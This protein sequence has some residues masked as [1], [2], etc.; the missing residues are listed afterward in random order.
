MYFPSVPLLFGDLHKVSFYICYKKNSHSDDYF[1]N[2]SKIL[3]DKMV[4]R[5][6]L[7]FL[8]I[9]RT[10]IYISQYYIALL[11]KTLKQN[12]LMYNYTSAICNNSNMYQCIR[13]V[14]CISIHHL[15]DGIDDCPY[16]DDESINNI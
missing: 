3:V 1:V 5:S 13:S 9:D 4:L 11:Y 6:D 2:I 12:N 14:K 15:L 10:T 7:F 8:F 16:M